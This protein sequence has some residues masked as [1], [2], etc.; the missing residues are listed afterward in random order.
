VAKK[1]YCQECGA[2]LI[3]TKVI[4]N[5]A[6][7]PDYPDSYKYIP[8]FDSETGERVYAFEYK[9]PNNKWYTFSHSHFFTLD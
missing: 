1:K 4:G 7:I 9:C 8:N 5:K 6:K 3:V 2:E